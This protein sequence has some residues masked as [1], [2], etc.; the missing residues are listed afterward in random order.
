M[1][2]N[3]AIVLRSIGIEDAEKQNL[4]NGGLTIVCY[5]ISIIGATDILYFGRRR[6]LLVRF[7]GMASAYLIWTLLS[8][9]NRQRGFRDGSVG[10]GVVTMIFVFQLFYNL[11]IGPVLPTYILEVM[12]FALR[13]KG[14]TIEQIFTY[15]AG[16][17]NGFVNPIAMEAL[18][19]K[20]Y[21][22]WVVMLCV[23]LCLVWLLFPETAGRTLEEV[24]QIF[25]G[26]DANVAAAARANNKEREGEDMVETV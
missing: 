12:P 19:W 10:I 2:F 26:D 5:G 13:A 15:G 22:V 3:L 18:E 11:S 17:F 23:W 20:Y 4:I 7:A 8:S 16:L 14:Y 24:S 25:D 6:I 9:I 1:S 21:I